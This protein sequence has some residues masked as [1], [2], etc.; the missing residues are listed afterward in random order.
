MCQA[1]KFLVTIHEEIHTCLP[2]HPE[3]PKDKAVPA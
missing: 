3:V 1:P 2:W